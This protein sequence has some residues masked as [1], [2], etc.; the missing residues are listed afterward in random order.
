[1]AHIY[2][3]LIVGGGPA[4]LTAG[5]YAA[6]AG[7]TVLLAEG[8]STVSQVTVTDLVENYP[9]I[10]DG[11]NGFELRERF[12]AQARQFGTE[13]L[14]ADVRDLRKET[15]GGTERWVATTD[16]GTFRALSVILA[17][18]AQWRRL[19]I[20][21]E[22]AFIG[23]GISF[24]ATCDG[25]FYR[26]RSVVVVGGGNTAIQEALFLTHFAKKVT[27]IHR[28]NRFRAAAVLQERALAHP[29]IAVLWNSVVEGF[30]GLDLLQGIKVRN[31]DTGAV[32]EY[33]TE[34]VFIFIGL[35]PNTAWLKGI[36]DLAGDGAI[37]VDENMGTA[38]PGIFACGDCIRKTLRQVVTACGD[39]ATAA[40]AAQLY[41]E[42]RKGQSY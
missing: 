31:V 11:I 4:G 25:P 39:G 17:T 24:C 20:A 13:V 9:G 12:K 34:G 40:Y 37:P 30:S 27:V 14:P 16:Q 28:R 22:E 10:P 26:D 3:V 35:L 18:G 7:L 2:D 29:K 36:L 1:M 41:V 33:P 21:G 6:R 8:S 15:E 38:V 42:A 19:G 32:Q 23:K 5:L